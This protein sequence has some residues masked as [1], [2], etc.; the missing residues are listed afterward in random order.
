ML[1]FAEVNEI[2]KTLPTGYYL[3]ER[4]EHKL[5]ANCQ[6]TYYDP[7]KFEIVISY[8]M[9]ANIKNISAE[10]DIRCLL[11]HEVSHAMLTPAHLYNYLSDLSDGIEYSNTKRAM[12]KDPQLNADI[13]AGKFGSNIDSVFLLLYEKFKS[14]YSNRNQINSLINI[15]E[16]QRIET[17]NKNVFLKV[18]FQSFI[19]KLNN[20]DPN[21]KPKDFESFFYHVVRFNDMEPEI[22]KLVYEGIYKLTRI[23]QTTTGWGQIRVYCG[24]LFDIIFA[25][26]MKWQNI[27]NQ[28]QQQAKSQPQQSQKGNGQSQQSQS[29]AQQSEQDNPEENQEQESMSSADGEDGNN[30]SDN[31]AGNESA[32]GQNAPTGSPAHGAG[33]GQF[34]PVDDQT[35]QA[36]EN[37]AMQ[38]NGFVD[39]PDNSAQQQVADIMKNSISKIIHKYDCLPQFNQ[40]A[41]AIILR[42]LKKKSIEAKSLAGYSGRLNPKN[43]HRPG[44]VENYR[45]FDKANPNGLNNTSGKFRINFFCDNSGSFDSNK[46]K[47]NSIIRCLWQLS[48]KYKAFEFTL[49]THDDD[50]IVRDDSN[51]GIECSGGTEVT[52]KIYGI[53]NSLQKVGQNVWNIVLFDGGVNSKESEK[54]YR[55]WNHQNVIMICDTCD[56]KII[57]KK[58]PNA[59]KIF[60]NNYCKELEQNLITCM[61]QMFR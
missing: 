56:Q 55:V 15:F 46:N 21:D 2:V 12:E 36:I 43:V 14:L 33:S 54:N 7:M 6:A 61:D 31:P 59:K 45:W 13:R 16:D 37:Q 23:N 57:E 28:M 27:Q 41:E 10:E 58:C 47:A 48:K 51:M 35:R 29:G 53:Y 38:D 50:H 8:P 18:N 11:Y 40:K 34:T 20:Y 26:A 3:G 1:T 52:Q 60:T 44:R 4:I 17:L 42:M 49:V 30:P 24:V 22:V 32:G 5:D 9:I 39:K 25:C 19:K